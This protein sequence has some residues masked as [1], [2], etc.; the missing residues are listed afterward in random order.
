MSE[1]QC[2]EK[3][4]RIEDTSKFPKLVGMLLPLLPQ[5]LANCL[6][7]ERRGACQSVAPSFE[8]ELQ[9]IDVRTGDEIER[10]LASF[11]REPNGW[12]NC[13]SEHIRDYQSRSYR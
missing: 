12:S 6:I 13:N 2:A 4:G 10:D 5:L 11:A 9:P 1:L 8:V 7:P 3:K